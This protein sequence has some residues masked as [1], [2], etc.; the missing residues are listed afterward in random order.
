MLGI[1]RER[2]GQAKLKKGDRLFFYLGSGVRC[3]VGE[4]STLDELLPNIVWAGFMP[5]NADPLVDWLQKW[6]V[7]P[8]R[9]DNL[10]KLARSGHPN[11][12]HF[13]GFPG[14]SDAPE[15]VRH[16]M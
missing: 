15:S 10:E 8:R 7:E 4:P 14:L 1:P 2:S 6:V 16:V 5:N 9:R 12:H 3:I 13:I 11:R